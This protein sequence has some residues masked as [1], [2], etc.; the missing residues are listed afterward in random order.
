MVSYAKVQIDIMTSFE[1]PIVQCSGRIVEADYEIGTEEKLSF[2]FRTALV[3]LQFDG[4]L[5]EPIYSPRGD[6][7]I[8]L[9]F[10]SFD[11]ADEFAI[12]LEERGSGL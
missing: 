3:A 10:P 8:T 12:A 1:E 5:T 4:T 11:D 2:A 9:R 7:C 6:Y